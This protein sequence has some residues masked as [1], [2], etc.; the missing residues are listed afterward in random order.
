METVAL[1]VCVLVLLRLG[2][3]WLRRHQ[4]RVLLGLGVLLA[5]RLAPEQGAAAAGLIAG[6]LVMG[7]AFWFL[8]IRPFQKNRR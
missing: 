2:G 8:P 3:Q 7:V 6:P 4:G 5:W 1:V